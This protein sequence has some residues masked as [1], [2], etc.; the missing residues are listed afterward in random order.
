EAMKLDGSD[1]G[2]FEKGKYKKPTIKDLLGEAPV[3]KAPQNEFE[4]IEA[5][6]NMRKKMADICKSVAA[7][8]GKSVD[9]EGLAILERQI[10]TLSALFQEYKEMDVPL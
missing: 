7:R 1:F 10:E 3:K 4:L 6:L 8:L 5:G 9:A 2:K